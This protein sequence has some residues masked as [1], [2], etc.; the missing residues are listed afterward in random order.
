MTKIELVLNEKTYIA[1]PCKL[2]SINFLSFIFGYEKIAYI[3]ERE[4]IESRS[5]KY[6]E[7]LDEFGLIGNDLVVYNENNFGFVITEKEIERSC[8]TYLSTKRV[9]RIKRL[10]KN[11]LLDKISNMQI[12]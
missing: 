7:Y 6:Y 3:S 8:E 5:F 9:K 12:N 4:I 2:Y 1:I 10:L 11:I